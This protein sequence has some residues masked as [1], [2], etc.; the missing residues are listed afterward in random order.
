MKNPATA[1][2]ELRKRIG[3]AE[4]KYGRLPGSVKLLAVTKTKLIKDIYPAID[5][6]QTDF[7]EN[8]VQE[9]I[10]KITA[11]NDSRLTWHFIGPIQSNKTR[12]I[13]EYFHWVHS[14]DR[15]K[16]ALRLNDLRPDHLPPLNICIQINICNEQSK[17]G[18]LPD[19]LR[20]LVKVCTALP[21]LRLRGLMALPV[22]SEN[23]DQQRV[24]FRRLRELFDELHSSQPGLDTLS[25]GT[26]HDME[27]A[28]AEGSTMVRIG[29]VLFG[30]RD[31]LLNR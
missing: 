11:I 1:L 8:Y 30:P 31:H 22:P 12:A 23:F 27:A 3:A 17:S 16:I 6:G 28:I 4:Q 7:A 29:T 9:A 19:A 15:A 18:I 20:E 13:A 5:C 10:G 26:S 24:P 21:R 2:I 25:M 14:L